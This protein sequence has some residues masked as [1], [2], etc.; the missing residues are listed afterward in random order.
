[1]NIQ[2]E[3]EGKI[4]RHVLPE[5]W[6]EIT[7]KQYMGIMK[8]LKQVGL[9]ELEKVVKVITILTGIKEEDIYRTEISALM[10]LGAGLGQFIG[11]PP[12]EELKHIIEIDGVEYG[13]H[14]KLVDLTF[15]EWVDIDT[16]LGNGVDDN[17]H[18]VMSVLYRP[19]IAKQGEKYQIEEYKPD[20]DRQE[21]FLNKMTVGDFYGVSVFFSDLGNELL[22][23][24][25]KSSMKE[26]RKQMKESTRAI[27]E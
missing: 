18:K 2:V 16:Y 13:F 4:T 3:K 26:L 27:I 10:K 24:T 19:I 9:R 7:I 6:E 1:M 11:Q 21:L 15:G 17:L 20:K 23:H 14:P 22:L 12:S 5:E 8:T 25:A